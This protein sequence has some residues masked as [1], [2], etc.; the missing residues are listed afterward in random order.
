MD[1][2]NPPPDRR[3]AAMSPITFAIGDIHGCLRKLRRVARAC[4]AYAGRRPA[5]WV[6][7]GDYLDRGPRSR[8]VVEFLIRRQ[9]AKPDAVV[10]LKGNHEQ[11]AIAAHDSPS[12][13]PTWL[14]NSAA[15]TQKS[16]WRS[17][18][19]IPEP[20]LSWLRALPLSHD[21]GLRFYVHAG[22]DLTVPLDA[23]SA[24][25]MLWMR[26]P[27][28]TDSDTIDCGR[29]VVH[30]HTP[31]R[32]GKPELRRHRL[33]LDTGAVIGGPLTAAAFDDTRAEPLGF[34]TDRDAGWGWWTGLV[35]KS[36]SL[37]GGTK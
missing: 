35:G 18:G 36:R 3:P 5:R 16:Y 7:L 15:A 2:P 17:G 13:M 32:S 21:D 34:V 9:R 37:F 20:H 28:L 27:F 22:I 26:E 6:F 12:A 11:L 8:G 33:N 31:L 25:T 29:F 4:Q 14:A 24:D 23:Q 1:A 10:C 30:G 19:W